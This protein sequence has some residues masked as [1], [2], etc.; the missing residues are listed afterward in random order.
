MAFTNGD[1]MRCGVKFGIP[2]AAVEW[3]GMP[4][5]QP[6]PQDLSR[7]DLADPVS[8][9]YWCQLFGVTSEQLRQAVAN[10]GNSAAR[11]ERELQRR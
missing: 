5:G 7:I 8:V 2:E 1:L 10:V 11:V 4:G 9:A 6:A 3:A